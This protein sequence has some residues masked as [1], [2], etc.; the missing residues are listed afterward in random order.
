MK[1]LTKVKL[2]RTDCENT[3]VVKV[4]EE[5]ETIIEATRMMLSPGPRQSGR[6]Y[7]QAVAIIMHLL[8][9]IKLGRDAGVYFVDHYFMTSGS[10]TSARVLRQQVMSLVE[11]WGLGDFITSDT[12]KVEAHVSSAYG[13]EHSCNE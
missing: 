2:Q 3:V 5:Q 8:D 6:T 7:A 4:T 11:E 10:M 13:K 9:E 12:V 1:V